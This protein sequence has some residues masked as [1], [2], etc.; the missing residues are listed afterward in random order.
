MAALSP[1]FGRRGAALAQQ[2]NRK[3]QIFESTLR[4]AGWS[5]I[6]VA[7]SD[8]QNL[9]AT[10]SAISCR[11][12]LWFACVSSN[13]GEGSRTRRRGISSSPHRDR[14]AQAHGQGWYDLRPV[15]RRRSCGER[16]VGWACDL[17]V[18]N[19]P[20]PNRTGPEW[21]TRCPRGQAWSVHRGGRR[22]G[23]E[24]RKEAAKMDRAIDF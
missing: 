14:D 2:S 7:S 11:P 22:R 10:I 17:G 1:G 3:E 24:R 16:A 21:C 19:I 6:N 9:F 13:R 15:S 12:R 20:T 23:I 5:W 4:I 18:R 8:T